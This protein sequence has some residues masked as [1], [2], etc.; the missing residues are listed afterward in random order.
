MIGI[1]MYYVAYIVATL[2]T[3][4]DMK[5]ITLII[6]LNIVNDIIIL[7]T[8]LLYTYTIILLR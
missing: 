1:S 8:L 7:A 6:Y 2:C 5:V 4:D 3:K